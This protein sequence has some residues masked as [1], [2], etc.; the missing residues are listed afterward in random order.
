MSFECKV[1]AITRSFGDAVKVPGVA[2]G[3]DRWSPHSIGMLTAHLR[4]PDGT[5]RDGLASEQ[6]FGQVLVS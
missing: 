1:F 2:H 4:A 3:I 6:K 5:H